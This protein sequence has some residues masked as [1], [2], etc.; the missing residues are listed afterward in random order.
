MKY[1]IY[2]QK[3]IKELD[4]LI[5]EHLD[6]Y[7]TRKKKNK[8]PETKIIHFIAPT[9]SG[10]TIISFGLMDKLIEQRDNL[11]FIWIAPNTLH[12]QSLEKFKNLT[13]KTVSDLSPIDSDEIE[14]DN[15]LNANDVLCLNWS[16]LDKKSNLLVMENETGKYLDN[17]IQKTKDDDKII[18][19]LID[20]SHIASQN[21]QTKAYEF[22]QKLNPAIQLEI[23]ATPKNISLSDNKV[24]ILED[25]VKAEGVIKKQFIFNDFNDEN[26]DDEKLVKY[27]YAKLQEI[28]KMYDKYTNGKIIPLMII[29]I[30]NENVD[31]YRKE[32]IRIERY[33][34]NIGINIK[35]QVACYLYEDKTN[36]DNLEQNNNPIQIVFTK[37]AI[38]TGWDC[39]RASVLLTFR[40]SKD[41]KFK[42]QVL[43]RINRMP[44][45]KHYNEILLDTAYVYA[46][47]SK[48]IPDDLN[49]KVKTSIQASNETVT[50]KKG[51]ENLIS[52]PL[53]TK[54]MAI[55]EFY[56]TQYNMT[57][58]VKKRCIE[59]V[60]NVNLDIEDI[61]SNIIQNLK[62]EHVQEVLNSTNNAKYIL[63]TD[64]IEEVISY[65]FKASGFD[66][67][68][69]KKYKQLVLFEA[70]KK[71]EPF[72][73]LYLLNILKESIKEL[74]D[75]T[76]TY[77]E[78]YKLVLNTKNNAKFVKL[79]S[80][81]QNETSKKRLSKLSKDVIFNELEKKYTLK[82]LPEKEFICDKSILNNLSIKSLYNKDCVK[83]FN[84]TEKLF[85][86]FLENN[87][88][89][90]C[91]YRNGSRGDYFCIPYKKDNIVREFF[92][93]FIVVYVDDTIGIYDTKS[94]MTAS[95]GEAKEKAEYL[96]MY[97]EKFSYKSGLIKMDKKADIN[98]FKINQRE[99]YTN[100]DANNVEWEELGTLK[101]NENLFLS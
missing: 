55:N 19:A 62:I 89:V 1:F 24:E 52:L 59:F 49:F 12:F 34:E 91:W 2:Q 38:A 46:N 71:L 22:L 30:E 77:L 39:P 45:L 67:L 25:D 14:S 65:L 29:Q 57:A 60:K 69:T 33:L 21:E 68:G 94:E 40:K 23:T 32:Q 27:A 86:S 64:E 73:T 97:C 47:V 26:V 87:D 95:D 92:P 93:D 8:T 76:L 36:S 20:E 44:E 9:G 48:Y 42:T 99:F 6:F 72:D 100:Y 61:T 88:N 74:K 3:A 41:D 50:I 63:S 5:D 13:D 58:F 15:I 53:F 90:K 101:D 79:L 66:G 17:I 28:T 10:K 18:I 70:E 16:S 4:E 75:E 80:D 35:N 83:D 54:Q 81:I 51:L 96:Y 11:V 37:T 85:V 98:Y 82:W 78:L 7:D 43:G 84:N 56:D 31:E